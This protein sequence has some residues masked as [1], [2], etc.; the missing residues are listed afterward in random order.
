MSKLYDWYVNVCFQTTGPLAGNQT[1]TMWSFWLSGPLL[2]YQ[3]SSQ[4]MQ[5]TTFTP[6]S[7]VMN[8]CD[9]LDLKYTLPTSLAANRRARNENQQGWSSH[10]MSAVKLKR[11]RY[12]YHVVIWE[13]DKEQVIKETS[14]NSSEW[15]C[16]LLTPQQWF[17]KVHLFQ[18]HINIDNMWTTGWTPVRQMR[19]RP[20]VTHT[21]VSGGQSTRG[22]MTLTTEAVQ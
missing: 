14:F 1:L 6:T 3:P 7:S 4:R 11:K 18:I 19:K 5:S 12:F 22:N 17:Y 10:C 15:V 2:W 20:A 16:L 9:C 13:T 8:R 21:L